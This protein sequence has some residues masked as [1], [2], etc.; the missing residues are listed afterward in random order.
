MSSPASISVDVVINNHN[1]GR[2]VGDAIRSAL[3]QTCGD[4]TVIVVDDGSTDHSREVIGSF[5]EQILTV[6]KDNGG[7]ASA[8]NAG[9]GHARGDVIIFLD[10]DDLLV[11][12]AAERVAL[13]FREHPGLA[14]VH[15]RLAVVNGDGHPTGELK[16]PSHIGLPEGDLRA[17]MTRFPF[18]MARPPTSGNA[19]SA[20]VL[21]R[22]APIPSTGKTAA[23]WYVVSV[24]ALYG[25]VGAIDEPLG[26]YREHGGNWYTIGSESLDLD[27]VHATIE[28][29]RLARGFLE[30]AAGQLGLPWDKRDASMCEVADRAISR[31][32][33]PASHPIPADRLPALVARGARAAARRFDMG[34]P[35]RA[36]FVVW[37]ALLAIAPRRIARPLAEMF[38]YPERRRRL[39]SS[40]GLLNWRR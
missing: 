38:I 9:L 3:D 20:E 24:A 18:D 40:L 26:S 34:V 2:Y 12:C 7:Q 37:L 22:I 30:R 21:R 1:Y 11:P 15:Y 8:F 39:L 28:R 14:K 17:A 33:E 25:P 13:A 6:F 16:P 32:L 19:F 31:K 4:V 5:G 27:H 35:L 29:T 10:A 23:D 36:A